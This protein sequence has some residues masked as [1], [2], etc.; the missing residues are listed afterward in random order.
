MIPTLVPNLPNEDFRLRA[1]TLDDAQ[2]WLDLVSMSEVRNYTSWE[3]R[4]LQAM[5]AYVDV[6]LSA[7]EDS[8]V[9]F[10]IET[11][12]G[13]FVGTI[14]L[15]SRS[16]R[17]RRAE[18]AYELHP[19][20]RGRGLATTCVKAVTTW[21]FATL[22][23][24]RLQAT[25]LDDNEASR[26]VLLKNGY[27]LEGMLEAYRMVRGTPRDYAILAHVNPDALRVSSTPPP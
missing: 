21:A 7:A 1:L 22:G 23:I 12:A 8:P 17:D 24:I 6:H 16:H 5:R 20:T 13:R 25:V 27:C 2:Q 19:D 3:M 15:H 18:I 14:G 11:T 9:R 10:A 26:R 4:D